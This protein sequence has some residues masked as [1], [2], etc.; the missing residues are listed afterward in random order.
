MDVSSSSLLLAS[1]SM[2][3]RVGSALD[4]CTGSGVQAFLTARH[5]DSVVAVDINPRALNFAAFGARLNGIANVQFR[6]GDL[7][8]PVARERF[9]LI[10]ANPPYVVSPETSLLLRDGGLPGDSFCELVVRRAPAFLEEGGCAHVVV[11]WVHR[12]DEHWSAPLRNWVADAGCDALLLREVSHEPLDYAALW[13]RDLRDDRGTYAAALDSWTEYHSRHGIE[14]IGSGVIVLRR[15]EG[16]TWIRAEELSS[17][18]LHPADHHI[19]RLFQSQDYLAGRDQT[20]LLD[21]RFRLADDHVLDETVRL[22]EG[23]GTQRRVLRLQNGLRW[24][25]AIDA[26]TAAVLSW[27]DGRR[28][29]GQVLRAAAGA[30]DDNAPPPDRFVE[31]G[32]RAVRRLV[33]LCFVVPVGD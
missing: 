19:A 21:D 3:R 7:Y 25:V 2:R 11:N 33:E 18:L 17:E 4:L 13:N 23:G 20:T 22:G 28:P 12:A 5:A 31:G 27:L 14:A 10:L 16:G 32:L 30:A 26:N 24:Q 15:R 8:E 1:V 6:E 29:L 9:G